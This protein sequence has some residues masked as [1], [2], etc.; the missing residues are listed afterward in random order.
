[1][2]ANKVPEHQIKKQFQ[3]REIDT[4][5]THYTNTPPVASMMALG[6]WRPD[7]NNYDVIRSLARVELLT[8]FKDLVDAIVPYS[9]GAQQYVD[10]PNT[11]IDWTTRCHVSLLREASASCIES[12]AQLFND[13]IHKDLDFWQ[14]APFNST[15]FVQ[16]CNVL[17][18]KINAKRPERESLSRALGYVEKGEIKGALLSATEAHTATTE[19]MIK[20]EIYSME[21][22]LYDKLSSFL[23]SGL[24]PG[25]SSTSSM[26]PVSSVPMNETPHQQHHVNGGSGSSSS[27]STTTTTTSTA[28]DISSFGHPATT[29]NLK[30]STTWPHTSKGQ[31]NDAAWASSF[32]VQKAPQT[33]QQIYDEWHYGWRSG[34]PLGDLERLYP[35]GKWRRGKKRD[36]VSQQV[37]S[38]RT[39]MEYLQDATDVEP[40]QNELYAHFAAV[41]DE[42]KKEVQRWPKIKSFLNE[43]LRK[44]KAGHE[45]R[46]QE[47][48][49]RR[50]K[51]TST[52]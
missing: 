38:R 29:I 27:S 36:A 33:L 17:K 19:T 21:T 22:R 45:A 47:M 28:H 41:T 2:E 9:A 30:D 6:G 1:M 46:S 42:Q 37:R 32:G 26:L 4:T 16:F 12:A 34:P 10:D 35:Q 50:K 31:T 51:N 3:H 18:E 8:E 48:S 15:R 24:A 43:N 11:T 25:A 49:K 7:G 40:L 39:I 23:S 13:N 44:R 20:K 5:R 52:E 14:Y